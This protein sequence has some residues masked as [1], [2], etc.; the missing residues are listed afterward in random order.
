MARFRYKAISRAGDALSG[1]L[2]A[3]SREAAI[4]QLRA[5]GHIPVRADPLSVK[6]VSF[7]GLQ[8]WFSRTSKV[9]RGQIAA[10]T[11][12]LATLLNAGL[13][14]DNALQLVERTQEP[15]PVRTLL[16]S[17]I[18]GVQSGHSLS[19]ALSDHPEAFDTLYISLVRAG[20]AGGT[21]HQSILGLADYLEGM[22]SLRRTII[23]ALIYPTILLVVAVA[24]LFLLLSFVI[25][26]F[27][28]LFQDAGATLP[29]LTQV[30]FSVARALRRYWWALLCLVAVAAWATDR[31]L[32]KP[33]N[34]LRFDKWCLKFP[35]LGKLVQAIDTAR[36]SRTLG[37]LLECGVPLLVSIHLA[38]NVVRNRSI[39]AGI[40]SAESSLEQGRRLATNLR[41][42][43]VLPQMAVQLIEVGEESGQLSEL[44]NRAAKIYDQDVQMR[45]Q[46]LL[47]I[48]EPILILSLG[49]V[50]AIIITSVLVAILGLN[51]LVI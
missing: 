34:R 25:P 12:Q 49:G 15:G 31:I 16:A 3:P 40:Q 38:H 13:P 2:E 46:R 14:L 5:N 1:E 11:R 36:L 27:I 37:T 28:P 50:I 30:V 35:V 32:A 17:V 47:T 22:E 43:K 18:S 20:E 7:A 26:Q 19:E 6:G 39:A 29:M 8:P 10:L 48:L 41:E 42:Q 21:L 4:E 9:R 23:T 45:L 51:D 33:E 24:S 44:L